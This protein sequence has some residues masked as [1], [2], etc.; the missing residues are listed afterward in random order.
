VVDGYSLESI[1]SDDATKKD[2]QALISR[3]P[4]V[5]AARVSPLQ[6]AILVNL[7][8]N[9]S[10]PA[11]DSDTTASSSSSSAWSC[12]LCGV[13][14]FIT[15]SG[16]KNSRRPVTLALGDGANDIGMIHEARVGERAELE[17][18]YVYLI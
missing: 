4:T 6:K 9:S 18:L 2:F 17:G 7:V 11:H 16:N 10:V 8:K 5:V 13:V 1:C 3:I 12:W 15:G 14:A